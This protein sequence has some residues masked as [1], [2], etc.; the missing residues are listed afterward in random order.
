MRLRL[1]LYAEGTSDRSGLV[2]G[3]VLKEADLDPAHLLIRLLIT[4]NTELSAEEIHFVE[5]LRTRGRLAQSSDFVHRKTLRQLLSW[6]VNGPDLALMFFDK[7]E[8][9]DLSTLADDIGLLTIFFPLAQLEEWLESNADVDSSPS[10][11]TFRDVLVYH[12]EKNE[13]TATPAPRLP[14][15]LPPRKFPGWQADRSYSNTPFTPA[16]APFVKPGASKVACRLAG[17]GSDDD[18]ALASSGESGEYDYTKT[19]RLLRNFSARFPMPSL[20]IGL[21]IALVF[22]S[23]SAMQPTLGGMA[24]KLAGALAFAALGAMGYV[25]R[26]LE[27]RLAANYVEPTDLHLRLAQKPPMHPEWILRLLLS[28]ILQLFVFGAGTLGT[29]TF[30]TQLWWDTIG[31]KHIWDHASAI[32]MV[33]GPSHPRILT[34]AGML[35]RVEIGWIER[36]PQGLEQHSHSFYVLFLDKNIPSKLDIRRFGDHVMSNVSRTQVDGRI[37]VHFGCFLFCTLMVALVITEMPIEL[38]T[39]YTAVQ[40]RNGIRLLDMHLVE[41]EELKSFGR[42]IGTSYVFRAGNLG[43]FY[44]ETLYNPR[45]AVEGGGSVV[46]GAVPTSFIAG[47]PF[48]VATDGYPFRIQS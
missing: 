37:W 35:S 39:A 24:T 11:A 13:I 36:G 3:T 2:P 48:L 7:N 9:K 27:E 10:L 30:A 6:P 5:P 32:E 31:E 41:K 23:A 15:M 47:V 44:E 40:F 26:F 28:V 21:A 20:I 42:P 14:E 4:E 12:L 1:V 8:G 22:V 46:I 17:V 34:I 16:R 29:A 18:S 25:F 19:M 38:R 45:K 33:E 43:E